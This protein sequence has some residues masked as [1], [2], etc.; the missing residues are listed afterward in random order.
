MVK[1]IDAPLLLVN[2]ALE[3]MNDSESK[4][5]LSK[6][7]LTFA[8]PDAVDR[9]VDKVLEIINTNRK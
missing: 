7:I 5:I 3:L 4:S 8:K 2:K 1:D 9:I 6:N